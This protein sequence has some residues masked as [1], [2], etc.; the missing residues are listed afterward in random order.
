M[1]LPRIDPATP[2]HDPAPYRRNIRVYYLF[3]ASTG[4][5]IFLPIWII[6]LM[7]GRGLSLTEVGVFEAVF[8]ITI[9]V[10]EVPT[11]AVADRFGRRVSLALGACLFAVATVIFAMADD[12]SLLL[13]SYLVMGIA[14][15]LYSG[16]GD[17]FLYDTLRVLGRTRE[18]E[19]LAGRSHGVFWAMM[20][21]ATA[22]G[23]PISYLIGYSATILIS[24]S[25][26]LVSAVFALLMH[27]PPRR[28]SDFPPD[29]LH[30]P[31][32][33]VQHSSVDPSR[34]GLPIFHEMVEGF[35]MVWRI[36]PVRY[37]V[38]FAAVMIALFDMPRFLVQPFVAQ[39]GLD[40]LASVADGFVWSALL[41]PAYL[42]SMIGML[43]AGQLMARLGERR[44]FPA[45]LLFGAV[46]MIP[47]V[48]WNHL[49]MLG[50]IF[51]ISIAQAVVRP[52]ASGYINRR[53]ASDQR[54][55]VL[56]IFSL[57]GGGAMGVIL[58]IVVPAADALSFPIAFGIA[59]VM[60][61]TIG[62]GLWYLWQLAHRRD[63]A[64]RLRQWALPI[65]KP[66]AVNRSGLEARQPD[67]RAANGHNGTGDADVVY[68]TVQNLD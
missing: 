26:F 46:F 20:V 4:F 57:I 31:P 67:P 1:G 52:I 63:Q 51:L 24:S 3:M 56:S 53:I 36:R 54:A 15:T 38:P 23:G 58:V 27:E 55:T 22:V 64:E 49:G 32:A 59:L 16:A 48:I 61:V 9:I 44:S 18:Y 50:A 60:V 39:H 62:A 35:R 13:G 29:P 42:G 12:F 34:A 37:L 25:F 2:A 33:D 8:W 41:V 28:E 17:A 30:A 11:G 68:P 21:V 10:A 45:V 66:Q 43:S 65:A 5:M 40:P 47:L 7:N 14:M 6:Y 19:R